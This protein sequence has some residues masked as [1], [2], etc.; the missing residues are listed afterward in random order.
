[1]HSKNWHRQNAR[2]IAEKLCREQ[3]IYLQDDLLLSKNKDLINFVKDG[4]KCTVSHLTVHF[5]YPGILREALEW[6][7][8][9][10]FYVKSFKDALL[11]LNI[12]GHKAWLLAG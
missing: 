1:L 4:D 12:H 11:L 2:L 10:K 8:L 3:Q 6:I 5:T 7:K 9:G